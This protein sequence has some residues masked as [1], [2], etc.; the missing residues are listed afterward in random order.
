MSAF[1]F[2]TDE[3]FD[4]A[5]VLYDGECP[6]C[7]A[8]VRMVTLGPAAGG[9]RLV[10][11]RVSDAPI[12]DKVTSRGFDLNEG[13]VLLIGERIYHGSDCLHVLALLTSGG[14]ILNRLSA[15]LFRFR[16]IARYVYPTLRAGRH[17]ALRLLGRARIRLNT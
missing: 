9:V 6:F 7:S 15:R 16:S 1:E 10:D 3:L 14:S 11:V 17:L 5:T 4:G 13:M 12:V 2:D 8:Y